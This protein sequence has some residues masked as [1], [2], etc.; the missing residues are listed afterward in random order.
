MNKLQRDRNVCKMTRTSINSSNTTQLVI[1][2]WIANYYILR[3]NAMVLC[4]GYVWK[5]NDN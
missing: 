2:I 5:K 1:R 4:N 3:Y